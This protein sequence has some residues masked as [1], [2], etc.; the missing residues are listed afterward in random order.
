MLTRNQMLSVLMLEGLASSGLQII[1]IRQSVPFVGSSILST[2][3]IISV[4]LGA[5]A[6]GYMF[7]GRVDGGRY[8]AVLSRNLL[9]CI[10]LFGIG[11]SYLF[12][13]IFYVLL[14]AMTEGSALLSS[15]LVHVSLFSMLVLAPLVFLLAQTVPLL[16]NSSPKKRHSEAAGDAT[17][18]STIGNVIGCLLTS[19]VLMHYLGVAASIVINCFILAICL[20]IIA[21]AHQGAY[22]K[23]IPAPL[24]FLCF[25]YASNISVGG[26]YL[27]YD[28]AYSNTQIIEVEGGRNL[29]VNRSYASYIG[30]DGTSTHQYIEM[31]RNGI[32]GRA[33]GKD[34]L[35]LGSGG[36]TLT[37]EDD[38]FNSV[39]YV[40]IDPSLVKVSEEKFL[41][42]KIAGEFHAEDARHYLIRA[43]RQWDFIVVDVYTNALSVPTHISTAEFY[44]LVDKRLTRT[45]TAVINMLLD[46]MLKDDYSRNVDRT[47]RSSFGS[48]ITDVND[49]TAPVSNVVYF[50]SPKT[51]SK[52]TLY[53]DDS[54]QIDIDRFFSV[55][56]Q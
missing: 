38:P 37:R 48:C 32:V 55:V 33:A 6:A 26:V 42:R 45:G 14:A 25:I 31:A 28:N 43:K 47:I 9:I 34:M 36:F 24:A 46:P 13:E 49:L 30:D 21:G 8:R 53:R 18:F 35:V 15:P 19:L 51:T 12:H 1:A 10:P 4:F 22:L 44:A 16:L 5:L 27:E 40:D 39:I 56:T 54:T 52:L 29:V 11:M 50:C 20:L 7:G 41:K 17:A 3:I 2:S 23:K